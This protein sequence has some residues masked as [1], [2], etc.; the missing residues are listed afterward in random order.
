MEKFSQ[1]EK[2]NLQRESI[3]LLSNVAAGT[4]GQVTRLIQHSTLMGTIFKLVEKGCYF[5]VILCYQM[6][7]ILLQ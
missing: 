1:S 4:P 2:K 7:V 3:W 6:C 5:E